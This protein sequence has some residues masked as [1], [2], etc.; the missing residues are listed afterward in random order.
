MTF[1]YDLNQR[2]ANLNNKQ[3]LTESKKA[4]AT[5]ADMEEGNE[6]SGELEKARAAGKKEFE[7]DGK[8]Y[9]VKEGAKPDYIDLDKDGNRKESMKKAAADKKAIDKDLDEQWI[10]EK[11]AGDTELN[12]EKKGMFKGKTKTELMSQL[13]K[14]KASGPHEKGSTA[15]TK[16][17]QLQFA[18]RAKKDWK[19]GVD[20][21]EHLDE[22]SPDTLKSYTKKA[23]NSAVNKG[24]DLG[25]K[26]AD[27]DEVDRYTN[28]HFPKGVDQFGQRELMRKAAG[29]DY[30][31]INK[32][33]SKAAK[34]V[35]GIGKAVDRLTKE[36]ISSDNA[37]SKTDDA[38]RAYYDKI[39][40]EKMKRASGGRDYYEGQ[41][42]PHDIPLKGKSSPGTDFDSVKTDKQTKLTKKKG[43]VPEADVTG[44]G[45]STG[46]EMEDA[47][48]YQPNKNTPAPD[49][50][51]AV[52][53][54]VSRK[55]FQQI[56]ELL[57]NIENADKRAELAHHHADIFAQQNPRFDRNK[58]FNAVGIDSAVAEG[59]GEMDSWLKQHEKEQTG[60]GKFDK[61]E[62]TLPSGMKATTYTRKPETFD[63]DAEE[64]DLEGNVVKRGRGRPKKVAEHGSGVENMSGKSWQSSKAKAHPWNA[65]SKEMSE[66]DEMIAVVDQGEYDREGDMAKDQ[67]S[68]I[69]AAA[70]EL[71]SILSDDE[72]LPEWVQSKITKAM[73]YIDTAR[74]YMLSQKDQ[75]VNEISDKTVQN[76]KEKAWDEF[77][78]GNDKRG[79]GIGRALDKQRGALGHVKT[80]KQ[81]KELDE[82]AVSKKQQKFMGM[83]HAAQKGEKP[84]SKAVATVAKSMGKK[85]AED[86][87]ATKH[88]G[89]PEK[90]KAKKVKEEDNT[91][92]DK[93][94]ESKPGKSGGMEFGKGIYESL[95]ARVENMI[96]ENMNISVNM[97]VDAEG[98]PN[99]SITVTADGVDADKLAELLKMAGI[100]GDE[101][102][103]GT[104]GNSPCG[105]DSQELEEADVTVDENNPDWPTN[106]E[107]SNDPFQYSGGLNKPKS[108]GQTTTGSIPNLDLRRQATMES[109]AEADSFLNLF[110]VF[111]NINK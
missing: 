71:S 10:T 17:K 26:Q 77:A 54:G 2:L 52:V 105:C 98:T 1:F 100:G 104:C 75:Q 53:E 68:T 14:L 46:Y 109:T 40:K 102:V 3:S 16:M 67:L 50:E 74:D 73:D 93:S 34:R 45:D 90:V 111:K 85:D 60:T 91:V 57:R 35:A 101:Q 65:E 70:K 27:A 103:C 24:F 51:K 41:E 48:S 39:K 20:E 11:W 63:P 78:R 81:P 29:A 62:R 66:D 9:P 59:W 86:F 6:F 69:K 95:N 19:G 110:K 8:K 47:M 21:S 55:H 42:E 61:R 84:A 43:I 82:K 80:T 97:T 13:N 79:A 64:K 44:L 5:E 92:G 28:R 89:L 22:L 87:A 58:F 4:L 37:Q 31:D 96:T 56:A 23:A 107:T 88:K 25:K 32:T 94:S 108:T 18:I 106:Q 83:V 15:F 33:R 72:N 76:Y 7:V 30:D 49:Y 12:P 36:G 99:K 38:L